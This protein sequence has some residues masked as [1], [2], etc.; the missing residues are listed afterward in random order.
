M[1]VGIGSEEDAPA[2]YA[3]G[4]K[5]VVHPDEVAQLIDFRAFRGGDTALFVKPK[6][7]NRSQYREL[8]RISEGRG[9]F[10]VVGHEPVKLPDDAARRDFFDL[11]ALVSRAAPV[12]EAVGR[13]PKHSYSLEQAEAILRAYYSP[14]PLNDVAAFADKVLGVEPG[15]IKGHWVK[16]LAR[17]Y[18]GHAKRTPPE[19]WDGI[20]VD[21]DGKPVHPDGEV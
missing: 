20:L 3:A 14:T 2:L 19:G 8:D 17:K 16:M 7:L 1:I 15:T 5:T 13:R 4:A 9:L 11:R 6:V 12:Q 21:A 10:Q 18:T